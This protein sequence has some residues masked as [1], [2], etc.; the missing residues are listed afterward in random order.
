MY[1][2]TLPCAG[3]FY[4]VYI[5]PRR[6][7]AARTTPDCKGLFALCANGARARNP[8]KRGIAKNL[9]GSEGPGTVKIGIPSKKSYKTS[10]PLSISSAS[11]SSLSA[12]R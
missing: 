3:L 8:E 2:T 9:S 5:L 12:I 1:K 4:F 11:S 10:A 7:G 6:A